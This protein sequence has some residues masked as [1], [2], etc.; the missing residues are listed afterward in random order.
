VSERTAFWITD[1]LGDADARAYIFGRGGDLEFP[2][3]V[4][5]KTGTSQAYHDNWTIGY[6]PDVTVGV[7]V[8]NFDRTPL[9]GS[10]GVT[11][12]GPI[13][14]AVMLAAQ[15]YAAGAA[16][17]D[18]AIVTR[19]ADLHEVTICALSGEPANAWC[20]SRAKEWLPVGEDQPPCSWHHKSDEGLLTVYP[21]VYRSWAASTDAR[22]AGQIAPE[23]AKRAESRRSSEG[24]KADLQIA[25]PPEGAVYSID[26]TLRRE[27]QALPLRAVTGRPTTVRWS[28][29]GAHI[30]TA[31]SER[32]LPWPLAV[33]S[34]RI[35]A[36]DAEGRRTST[37]VV[38]R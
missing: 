13:F 36:E 24:A 33:G 28:V 4:A 11:G 16:S 34:H 14:H 1:I 12:A 29:D 3:P 35:E 20:P 10:S 6:T 23:R 19:P 8:G 32:P 5:V 15:E 22:S 26:P 27:F 7:W 30:G 9:R 2:F 17:S 37:S 31:S 21:A 18:A 25:N 38:V